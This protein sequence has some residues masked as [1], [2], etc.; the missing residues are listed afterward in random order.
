MIKR[1]HIAAMCVAVLTAV[2]AVAGC[3][4]YLRDAAGHV[5]SDGIFSSEAEG[6]DDKTVTDDDARSKEHEAELVRWAEEHANRYVYTT[7]DEE[8]RTVYEEIY[9]VIT[10]HE[11]S[12]E[13]STLDKD[14]LDEAYRAVMADYGELFWVS[15]YSY[16]QYTRG[17]TIETLEF[18]PTYTLTLEERSAIQEQI[19][20]KVS[21]LLSGISADASDYEKTRYVF[22]YLAANVD[23]VT[24]SKD[25]QNII[26]VFLYGQTVCQGY[27]C[28]TQ[29]L[30]AELGVQSAV[31]TGTAEGNSH[32]WNLVRMDGEYYYVDTTWGNSAYAGAETG[33]ER[34][35]NYNYFGITTEELLVTHTPSDDFALPECTATMDNYYIRE[36]RYF[37]TWEPDA[38]GALCR[39][40]YESGNA[41]VPVKF[42]TEELYLQTKQYF[43]EEQHIL[44]YCSGIKT[45]YYVEDAKQKVLIFRF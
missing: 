18:A 36:N 45:L 6:T 34:F 35:I 29:Y 11:T 2:S 21:E 9:A 32:A 5:A 40:G 22:D 14:V 7:L 23:Y 8:C 16:T 12:I 4:S 17:D 31:V 30:L 25:N 10:E 19:D 20:E 38:I 44:D 1:K 43:I 24:G 28:A 3:G 15:G 37:A 39:E 33:K 41:V 27:A 42:A 26:S 13:V